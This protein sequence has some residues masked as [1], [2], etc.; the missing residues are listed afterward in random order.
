MAELRLDQIAEMTGGTILQGP[1]ERVFRDFNIDS[2]RTTPGAL[3]F[4]IGVWRF[5]FD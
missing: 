4:A 1:P 5:K 3:F 2:R